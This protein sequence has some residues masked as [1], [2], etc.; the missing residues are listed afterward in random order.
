MLH[1]N[2]LQFKLAD[3]CMQSTLSTQLILLWIVL[4]DNLDPT[5][6]YTFTVNV[7]T[8]GANCEAV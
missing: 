3:F 2:L 1:I 5:P 4:I 8:A 7:G 6:E